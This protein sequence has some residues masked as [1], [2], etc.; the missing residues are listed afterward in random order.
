[1]SFFFHLWVLGKYG[2]FG[3][4]SKLQKTSFF[5]MGFLIWLLISIYLLWGFAYLEDEKKE[6]YVPMYVVCICV[7]SN[8]D[9]SKQLI[10]ISLNNL[11]K[12]S[13]K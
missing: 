7:F 3:G 12:K 4:G 2:G 8:V 10:I 9:F 1:M 6:K 13:K 11:T 5:N